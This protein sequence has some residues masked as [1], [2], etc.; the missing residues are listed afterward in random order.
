MSERAVRLSGC[1]LPVRHRTPAGTESVPRDNADWCR[2]SR[3]GSR[4]AR[5][6]M[7]AR[8]VVIVDDDA[9]PAA[10]MSE[11]HVSVD[12]ARALASRP[13]VFLPADP[14]RDGRVV[15][16]GE[17]GGGGEV[18]VAEFVTTTKSGAPRKRPK[19]VLR[20]SPAL[21]L[22]VQAAVPV[23]AQARKLALDD[24]SA[25]ADPASVFW[26]TAALLALGLVARG[27]LLPGVSPSGYDAW[28]IG[29]FD[30]ED[31]ERV[32]DLAALMPP[33]ARAVPVPGAVDGTVLLP[34][35][36]PLLRAFLDAVA[37]VLPRT[38]GAARMVGGGAFAAS[39]AEAVPHLRSW[40]GE[41][42]AGIDAGAR[43]A[44]D[45][46]ADHL[47]RRRTHGRGG[48]RGSLRR[49]LRTRPFRLRPR[50][51]P[52]EHVDPRLAPRRP[53]RAFHAGD[54]LDAGHG[55]QG[56]RPPIT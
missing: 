47:A 16:V 3:I 15:F 32:R 25:P 45:A 7:M 27:R 56:T 38:P 26:G 55:R 6:V 40:A 36:E 31:V 33:A 52:D 30:G 21:V 10:S 39:S 42:A 13:A 41:V 44:A 4:A 46:P 29:P 53:R 43:Y 50:R 22:P 11:R 37:D 12:A 5:G 51:R 17:D 23:L 20:S 28:R 8:R 34:E 1:A 48:R 35:T 54:R 9:E 2:N 49:G 24:P 18:T 19:L 14:P